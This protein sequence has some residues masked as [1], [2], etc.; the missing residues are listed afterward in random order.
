MPKFAMCKNKDC[1]DKSICYRFKAVP[2][3]LGQI[4]SK[5]EP[6]SKGYCKGLLPILGRAIVNGK[7]KG[8]IG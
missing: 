4:Y 8:T 1:K 2:S 6:D 5:F 7:N 3:K